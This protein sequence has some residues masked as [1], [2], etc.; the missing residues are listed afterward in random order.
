M[1]FLL[2][3][4]VM[5][6]HCGARDCRLLLRSAFRQKPSVDQGLPTAQRNDVTFFEAAQ[7]LHR[8]PALVVGIV[9]AMVYQGSTRSSFVK[10]ITCARKSFSL[11]CGGVVIS[12]SLG[13]ARRLPRVA[14]CG[15]WSLATSSRVPSRL[16][17]PSKSSKKSWAWAP[18]THGWCGRS[19][20][21]R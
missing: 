16:L 15:A 3:E 18:P 21:Y 5:R 17:K 12:A 4:T 2:A 20:P 19:H 10:L 7:R 1:H 14:G 11:F 8:W 13:A 9:G 6:Q